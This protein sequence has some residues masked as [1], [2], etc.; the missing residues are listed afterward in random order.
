MLGGEGQGTPG[1]ARVPLASFFSIRA[2]L[3]PATRRAEPEEP[4][5]LAALLPGSWSKPRE[6]K[7]NLKQRLVNIL[8][9]DRNEGWQDG[10]AD[11]SAR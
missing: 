7:V 1:L 9:Q 10:E 2:K 8:E 6:T 3:A 4:R 11:E 5:G